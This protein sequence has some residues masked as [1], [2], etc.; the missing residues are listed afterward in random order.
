MDFFEKKYTDEEM[1]KGMPFDMK[2]MSK[3]GFVVEV[4]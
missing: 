2:R 1:M 3:G 4:E